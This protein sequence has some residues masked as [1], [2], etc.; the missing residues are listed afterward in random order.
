MSTY[1][2]GRR[3]G[4]DNCKS[5][6]YTLIN[7]QRVC[8]LGHV[9]E[10]EV[11]VGE[12]EDDF[13]QS[14]R[15]IDL[16][17][18]LSQKASFLLSQKES[19]EAE[20]GKVYYGNTGHAL[21]MQCFQYIVRSQLDWLI[22]TKEL[23]PELTKVVRG[24]FALYI[25]ETEFSN[26]SYGQQ[27][28]SELVS[29][30][31]GTFK[32]DDSDSPDSENG[33]T[34]NDESTDGESKASSRPQIVVDRAH[35]THTILLCYLGCVM[36]RIPVYIYDFNRWIYRYEIPYMN[37]LSILPGS[38]TKRL[39]GYYRAMLSPRSAPNLG[40]LH[41]SLHR[42]V[43][44]F[45]ESHGLEFPTPM[46]E[47]LIF[48]VTHDLLLPPEIY[49]ATTKLIKTLDLSLGFPCDRR[50]LQREY[51]PEIRIV[52]LVVL[53]TKLYYRLDMLATPDLSSLSSKRINTI[54]NQHSQYITAPPPDWALWCDMLR[55]FW[56]E[57]ESLSEADDKE[58]FY[59]DDDKIDRYLTWY[60]QNFVG[61]G[62]A[63]SGSRRAESSSAIDDDGDEEISVSRRKILELFPLDH[64]TRH[65]RTRRE[66]I[67][68][69]PRPGTVAEILR[70]VHSTMRTTTK[71]LQQ[72]QRQQVSFAPPD[73]G[74][75]FKSYRTMKELP[76]VLDCL[77]QAAA[78]L[79]AVRVQVIHHVVLRLEQK[80]NRIERNDQ[81]S[82][83]SS[84][85]P[86]NICYS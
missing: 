77:Y 23:R 52:S 17:S 63:A 50:R 64:S 82:R 76:P 66:S 49:V 59:W 60:E 61:S 40:A 85:F 41:D 24:L 54:R 67:S 6:H 45:K 84:P 75:D 27:D 28:D 30:P 74:V 68:V 1:I 10:G 81:S 57:D 53:A 2:R 69:S 55:K 80:T 35:L 83:R 44:L 8:R 11:E 51:I 37:V 48:K 47:P 70:A 58:V 22:S 16:P 86:A 43:V 34:S 7:G 3:C 31:I 39:A 4:V 46:Y 38:M 20:H 73:Y 21:F 12:D 26:I 13:A 19:E 36:L 14:G 42:L 5:R 79:C 32:D 25:N 15:R 18:Q 9:Q 33:H 78:R 29:E 65:R 62:S 71:Q 56:I 72:R